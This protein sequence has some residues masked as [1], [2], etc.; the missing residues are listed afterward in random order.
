MVLRQ[1]SE[2]QKV[3]E[4]QGL[5]N[6]KGFWVGTVDGK[7]GPKTKLAVQKAQA[8]HKL[9]VTG[10]AD[11]ALIATL[12]M[13]PN[14]IGGSKGLTIIPFAEQMP[15]QMPTKGRYSKGYPK[16]AVVHF[17]ASRWR[18]DEST[19]NVMKY[20]KSQGHAYLEIAYSGQLMQAHAV[21]QWGNHGG[22]SG[23]K[24]LIGS[25]SDDLIGIEMAN[26]GKL[27]QKNGKFYAWYGEEI[28]KDLVRYVEEKEYGCP[29][30][31]YM[32]YSAAQEKT[33]VKTLLW[34]KANDP[35]GV[36]SFDHV[37]GHHE[38][39]GKLG[40]GYWRKNDPGGALSMPMAKLREQLRKA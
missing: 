34:L 2:G 18:T 39:A 22:V 4:L 20:G 9:T 30:G 6:A 38:V 8:V 19:R 25:V 11:L 5:L 15:F 32:R 40:L 33:L 17:D 26:A 10:E 13:A 14:P 23:W 37:L 1:G 7:F 36:F 35:V 16:G 31:F 12:E 21:N 24:G 29:T 28:E 27:T 3:R